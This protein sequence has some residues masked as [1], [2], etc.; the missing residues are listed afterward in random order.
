MNLYD[1]L[2]SIAK[3]MQKKGAPI[4]IDDTFLTEDVIMG[5]TPKELL[6]KRPK[7]FSVELYEISNFG[8]DARKVEGT[9][10]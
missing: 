1:K 10:I 9:C 6:W 8:L 2:L 3:S 7:T 4:S 5:P